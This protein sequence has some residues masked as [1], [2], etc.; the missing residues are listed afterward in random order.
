MANPYVNKVVK[1]DGTTIIDISDT[2]ATASDV[3]SGA[4]LYLATGQ[5]VSGTLANGNNAEYGIIDDDSPL[6][7]VGLVGDMVI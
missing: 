5:K 6:V 4:Y 3:A 2:T 1:A 7:G